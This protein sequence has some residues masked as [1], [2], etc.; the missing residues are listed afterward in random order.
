MCFYVLCTSAQELTSLISSYGNATTTI[1]VVANISNTTAAK[2]YDVRFPRM[3]NRVALNRSHPV[4]WHDDSALSSSPDRGSLRAETD[5][6][7]RNSPPGL[8]FASELIVRS[9]I[10]NGGIVK[11]IAAFVIV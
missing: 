4:F 7:A 8:L 2:M 5:P 9:T 11:V 6:R 3:F 1:M 10:L